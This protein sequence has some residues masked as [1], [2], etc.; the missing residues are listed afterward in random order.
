MWLKGNIINRNLKAIDNLN[1]QVNKYI[2]ELNL[3]INEY[4]IEFNTQKKNNMN[5]LRICT[6]SL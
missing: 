2:M 5:S 6:K 4:G 1:L 3:E